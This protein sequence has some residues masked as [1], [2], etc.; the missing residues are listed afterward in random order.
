[1]QVCKLVTLIKAGIYQPTD[2]SRKTSLDVRLIVA[3]NHSLA[4]LVADGI[5]DRELADRLQGT[6]IA[7]PP[8]RA[9]TVDLSGFFKLFVAKASEATQRRILSTLRPETLTKLDQHSWPGNIRELETTVLRAIAQT[10]ANVLLPEDINFA[11][12]APP[13][14][15]EVSTAEPPVSPTLEGDGPHVVMSLSNQLE[16][17]PADERYQFLKG[18]GGNLRKP[19]VEEFAYRLRK[20]LGRRVGHKDLATA[21]APNTP[22]DTVRQY[23]TMSC[24]VKITELEC[25]Q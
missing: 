5:L 16:T 21:L 8:L 13:A 10:S 19:V 3:T 22:M 23:I 18:L 9:R 20:K 17:L 12:I 1:M 7:I 11:P 2:A 4:D 24:G 15:T 25:N 14:R 6:M